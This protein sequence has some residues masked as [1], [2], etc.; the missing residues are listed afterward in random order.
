MFTKSLL[1][2]YNFQQQEGFII[3]LFYQDMQDMTKLA[4][5]LM[6]CLYKYGC[7][8]LTRLIKLKVNKDS[9]NVFINYIFCD[10]SHPNYMNNIQSVSMV[11]V[12]NNTP[13]NCGGFASGNAVVI[14]LP[15]SAQYLPFGYR[16]TLMKDNVMLSE[17]DSV[18]IIRD[19]SNKYVNAN[20]TVDVSSQESIDVRGLL[21]KFKTPIEILNRYYVGQEWKLKEPKKLPIDMK[22][23]LSDLLHEITHI[24]DWQTS[25]KVNQFTPTNV[26]NLR[27]AGLTSSDI[28]NDDNA[29]TAFDILYRL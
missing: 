21:S 23:K 29:S 3:D 17:S 16:N 22:R 13:E 18:E 14:Y 9:K 4:Y 26:S 15:M 19:I 24:L 8:I 25:N 2:K 10:T 27:K 5:P 12:S 11:N 28:A 6:F 7:F 20:Y 1:E